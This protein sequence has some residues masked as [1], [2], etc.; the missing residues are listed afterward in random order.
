MN[1]IN[2][3]LLK[4]KKEELLTVRVRERMNLRLAEL[5]RLE[6]E[7]NGLNRNKMQ[8]PVQQI[9][10]TVQ[11]EAAG[12]GSI[13]FDYFV[14]GAY[15]EPVYEVRALSG[16]NKI[17]LLQNAT[18]YQNTGID[19]KEVKL[20]LSTGNP[21]IGQTKP[22][23]SPFFLDFIQLYTNKRSR[24]AGDV[25]MAMSATDDLEAQAWTHAARCS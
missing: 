12:N 5:Q 14:P 2:A 10:L 11:A 21:G 1:N 24:M 6:N 23:L 19:W 3:E 13:A 4:I 17:T 20:T 16:E 22:V 25:P 9:I 18:V 7:V 8:N 15:W